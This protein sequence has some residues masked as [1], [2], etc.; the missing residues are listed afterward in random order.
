MTEEDVKAG[1]VVLMAGLAAVR[2][3]EFIS[4][5]VTGTAGQA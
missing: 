3:S 5:T 2:P 4:V 1:E